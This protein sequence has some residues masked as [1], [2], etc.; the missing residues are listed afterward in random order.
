MTDIN[1]RVIPEPLDLPPGSRPSWRALVGL[2]NE[3]VA[4]NN[5]KNSAIDQL[6]RSQNRVFSAI[7]TQATQIAN[8]GAVVGQIAETYI[9]VGPPLVPTTPTLSTGLGVINIEWDGFLLSEPGQE[10]DE[11]GN[12]V[13][14]PGAPTPVPYGETSGFRYVYAEISPTGVE[15]DEN[16]DEFISDWVQI[17]QPLNTAGV[18]VVQAE[19]GST[20]YIRLQSVNYSGE[21]SGY[22][23]KVSIV[24]D[25]VK[26]VDVDGEITDAID[27]AV[28]ASN[29]AVEVANGKITYSLAAPTDADGAGKGAGSIWYRH[30]GTNVIGQWEW[31][32]TAPWVPRPLADAV[33]ANLNAGKITAGFLDVARLESQSITTNKLLIADFAGNVENPGFETGTLA[34]W[35]VTGA[36][37]VNTTSPHGGLNKAQVTASAATKDIRS[38]N[39]VEVAQDDIWV[40]T[41]WAATD[42]NAGAAS[43]GIVTDGG[44]INSTTFNINNS[45]TWTKYTHTYTVPAG[46]KNIRVRIAQ[47]GGT[48]GNLRID[49]VSLRRVNGGELIVDGA[50]T[51]TKLAANA[52]TANE[53]AANAVTANSIAAGA[54]DGKIITGATVRTAASGQR[55]QLSPTGLQA[56]NSGGSVTATLSAAS[57]GLRL[58]GTLIAGDSV[59]TTTSYAD[60]GIQTLNAVSGQEFTG[61]Y[62]VSRTGTLTTT[63]LT[64]KHGTSG[65]VPSLK[66]IAGNTWPE[67]ELSVTAEKVTLSGT[68]TLQALSA[69]ASFNVVVASAITG[70]GGTL[71]VNGNLTVNGSVN[72]NNNDLSTGSGRVLTTHL[73]YAVAQGRVTIT[74]SAA[75]TPTGVSV[76][77]PTSRF[78]TA[79]RVQI[80]PASSANPT[81]TGVKG[82]GYTGTTA[83]GTTVWL[84]RGNTTATPV[85]WTATQMQSGNADG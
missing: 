44:T 49:D 56:F 52:V 53:L 80:T 78:T 45:N 39:F 81:T 63:A 11:N 5:S 8:Q 23:E 27:G 32:G 72:T 61:G 67:T 64:T 76:T 46:V 40:V 66:L 2:V 79:P 50:I 33:I 29:N 83:S 1:R 34:G 4:A 13:G 28:E 54:I 77:F 41:V 36:W 59:N 7:G 22:S 60:D 12:P 24:V 17:G 69:T 31:T 82:V 3:L 74:P 14:T 65:V 35:T 19:V 48:T 26:L 9:P 18:I 25:G 21:A 16:N 62:T 75:D 38:N 71:G 47:A 73:P 37:S 55:L 30:D 10:Y 70:N 15:E 6:G 58:S 42:M 68:T 51:T 85:D 57:G 20:Q 43:V 84:T